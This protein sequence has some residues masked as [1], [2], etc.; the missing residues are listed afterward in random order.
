MT[1]QQY[2]THTHSLTHVQIFSFTLPTYLLILLELE[3][4]GDDRI[5][6][7]GVKDMLRCDSFLDTTEIRWYRTI[8][9]N[10]TL[11]SSNTPNVEY[12]LVPKGLNDTNFTCE[13]KTVSGVVVTR[14]VEIKVRGT[15]SP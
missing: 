5:W 14:K 9:G 7:V 10:D 6:I 4:T 2:I 12:T 13:A 15:A 1:E 11:N 3:V 8:N